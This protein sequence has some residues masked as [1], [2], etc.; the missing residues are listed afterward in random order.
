MDTGQ[1]VQDKACEGG[2]TIVA[3]VAPFEGRTVQDVL[4]ILERQSQEASGDDATQFPATVRQEKQQPEPGAGKS[5][6]VDFAMQ[7]RGR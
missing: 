2:H 3:Y 5:Q 1:P 4:K 7:G 6:P